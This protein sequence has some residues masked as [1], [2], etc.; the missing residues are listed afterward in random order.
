MKKGTIYAAVLVLACG[1]AAGAEE[2]GL[3]FDGR[4]PAVTLAGAL[5]LSRQELPEAAAPVKAAATKQAGKVTIDVSLRDG[6]AVRTESVVC[7]RGER[8]AAAKDCR[9][10]EDGRAL[11]AAEIRGL[12][13][14]NYLQPRGVSF[15]A[16]LG[17]AEKAEK[18]RFCHNIVKECDSW[19]EKCNKECVE[20]TEPNQFGYQKCLASDWVC[21]D[22]CAH[23][24]TYCDD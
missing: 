13:L 11:N 14:E 17:E 15:R 22:V 8:G 12:R 20:W 3:N 4:G 23:Y 10:Q 2:K 1:A 18:S 19:K 21:Y 6:A 16:L 7:G 5:E 9:R 24:A